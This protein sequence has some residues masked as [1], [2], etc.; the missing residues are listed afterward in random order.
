[1][2]NVINQQLF[3]HVESRSA[4]FNNLCTIIHKLAAEGVYTGE[5]VQGKR[6]L[7][8]FRLTCNR[9]NSASQANID[10][11]GFDALFR[12]GLPA[13]AVPTEFAVG[14]DG[15]VVFYASG[16]HTD[17]YVKLAKLPQEKG[18][19]A[20]DS[21]KLGAGDLVAFRLL[22]PGSYTIS[23]QSGSQKAELTVL[24]AGDRLYPD[25]TKLDP[26]KVTLS[27]KS[28][29]PAKI[30]KWPTQALIISIETAGAALDLERVKS[31]PDKTSSRK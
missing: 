28:F 22:Q 21:R 8:T 26:V 23:N 15:Y 30:E 20:F 13:A 14:Q 24:S 3:R 27:E 7:G 1:M 5:V 6:L 29:A 9:K 2:K 16:H 31:A 10:L 17:L 12:A 19:P 11:S 25:L 18:S 4:S